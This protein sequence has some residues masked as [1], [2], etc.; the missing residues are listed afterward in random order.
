MLAHPLHFVAALAV[1]I[2]LAG[3]VVAAARR[4]RAGEITYS[5][6][7]FLVSVLRPNPWIERTLIG[8]F[9]G[10]LVALS[11]AWGGPLLALPVPV[12]G[13]VFI[14]VDTSGSMA[15]TDVL[16]SRSQAAAAAA[17]AFI[18]ASPRGTRIGLIA[19]STDASIVQP[20][21]TDRAT[22]AGA[23]ANLP[24]PNGAT[25]IGDALALAH[26]NLPATGH[27]VVVL[28]TD[29]VNN[30][31]VDPLSQ[32]QSLG[33]A[34]IPVYTIGIGT[35]SGAII[36]GTSE[37]ATIDEDALRSYAQASG[38]AYA[39]VDSATAL[40]EALARLGHVT[41]FERKTVD[42]AFGFAAGGSLLVL[43]A[44]VCAFALGRL[45]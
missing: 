29:G 43:A 34:H 30:R 37:E 38:G 10:G 9:L 11:I 15:S 17:R 32:A 21:T 33:A 41:G 7:A 1:A 13:A 19:F 36:P 44:G 16:P 23:V 26:A 5:N 27:R 20:L 14:C 2:V 12:N 18:A 25:A 42:A 35:N 22:L 28:V 8:L 31:G 4:K 40:R 45:P 6:L 3:L 24:A 39:R